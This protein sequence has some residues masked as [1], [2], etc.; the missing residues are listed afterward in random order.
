MICP[1]C[2]PEHIVKNSVRENGKQ[3]HLCLLCN[4]QFVENPLC[5]Y[6]IPEE[7]K[8]LI[9]R[10]LLE[11]IPLAGT[12]RAAQISERWLQYYVNDLYENVPEKL[13]VLPKKRGRLTVECD[14]MWSFV[15]NKDNRQWIRLAVDRDTREITGVH[16]GDRSRTGARALW[17]SLPP[18]Y[19]QCSVCYTDFR[20][21]KKLP[22][23]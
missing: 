20:A 11:K 21:E 23:K 2:G 19:R 6:R 12:A 16:V 18:V 7:T 15:G 13:T 4:R 8:A 1:Q 22:P 17:N 5:H 3:N 14:E 9:D 10:L